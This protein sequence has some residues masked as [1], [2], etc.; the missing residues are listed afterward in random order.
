[1]WF[2]TLYGLFI[3]STAWF[4]HYRKWYE[5][6]H[7][8]LTSQ[9]LFWAAVFVPLL[10]FLY[11]GFFAWSGK[12][13]DLSSG[14]LNKFID[15]SKLPLGLLSLSIPFVAIITSL[16][17]SIQTATQIS[18]A[19]SQIALVKK[20]NSLDELFLRE[21]N[22]V[23]KCA[24]IE[25]QVG[26]FH[27]D[28]SNGPGSISYKIS[29][30]HILFHKIY[31][32]TEKNGDITYELTGY[33]KHEF[34]APLLMIE[35]NLK[36][37]YKYHEENQGVNFG[38]EM[39]YLYTIVKQLCK[40]LDSLYVSTCQVPYFFIHGEVKNIQICVSSETDL[41]KILRKCI[42]LSE[43]LFS[44]V[45]FPGDYSLLTIRKYVFEGYDLFSLFGNGFILQDITE[46][47]WDSTVNMFN[48][49]AKQS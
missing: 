14:G 9:K 42:V 45:N 38:D 44:A 23:D 6:T 5:L 25:K 47:D 37:L 46:I 39:I 35:Q 15:I 40:A 26:D 34:L 30:P 18:T 17:R 27:I 1:M 33:I 7:E 36:N 21:K 32:T 10:S 24:F 3:L 29:S 13:V 20:K 49:T 2:L 22:F 4:F 19:N 12:T 8:P 16:H 28:I 11:F 41:K 48:H 31:D 43:S